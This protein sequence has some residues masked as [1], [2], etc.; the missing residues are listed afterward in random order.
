MEHTNNSYAKRTKIF[1]MII[2]LVISIFSFLSLVS[3]VDLIINSGTTTVGGNQNYETVYVAS[4]A[5]LQVDSSIGWLNITATNITILGTLN[6]LGMSNNTG[7]TA[8]GGGSPGGGGGTA[9]GSGGTGGGGGSVGGYLLPGIGGGGGGASAFQTGNQTLRNS[10]L[11]PGLGGGGGG[12]AGDGWPGAG[13]SGAVGGRG[14]AS[15]RLNS[16]YI[17]ITGTVTV[18]GAAGGSGGTAAC[19]SSGGFYAG[20]G[21]GGGGGANAGELIIDG[22]IVNVTGATL[23]AAGGSGGGGGGTEFPGGGGATGNGGRIKIFYTYLYNQSLSTSYSGTLGGTLYY[24]QFGTILNTTLNSPVNGYI[25]PT[26]NITFNCSSNI[27]FTTD[28]AFIQA[29]ELWTNYTGVWAVLQT[30]NYLASSFGDTYNSGTG[31]LNQTLW[32]NFTYTCGFGGGCLGGFCGGDYPSC[33]A[34]NQLAGTGDG[35]NTNFIQPVSSGGYICGM[36]AATRGRQD[37]KDGNYY[38]VTFNMTVY[39]TNNKRLLLKITNQSVTSTTLNCPSFTISEPAYQTLYSFQSTGYSST[40][41]KMYSLSINPNGTFQLF[42]STGLMSTTN[43]NLNHW[44][45]TWDAYEVCVYCGSGGIAAPAYLYIYNMSSQSLGRKNTTGIFNN[46]FPNLVPFVWNCNAFD[47]V[48]QSTFATA[49]RSISVD[50]VPP[51]VNVT[52]PI[53]TVSYAFVGQN[54][55]V[56]YTVEDTGA[57]SRCWLNYNN[58]N[59][60][61][62]CTANTT[63]IILSSQQSLTIYA[64]DTASNV[65]S[66]L[67]S[68]N[69]S[70][71]ENNFT[72]QPSAYETETQTFTINV[73][74]SNITSAYLNYNGTQYPTTNISNSVD[75]NIVSVTLDTP[76]VSSITIKS[77]NW[78]LNTLS[79]QFT[80]TNRTQTIHPINFTYCSPSVN[81]TYVNFVYY[82]EMPPNPSINASVPQ[83]TFNYWI[84]SGSVTK[85]YFFSN[86]TEVPNSRFCFSPPNKTITANYVY[87]AGGAAYVTRTFNSIVNVTYTNSSTTTNLYLIQTADSGPVTIQVIDLTSGNVIPNARVTITRQISGGQVI[88]IFDGYTDSAGTVGVWLSSVVSYTITAFKSGCGSN[89]Q[90]VTPVGSYNIQLNCAGNLTEYVSDI[91]GITYQRTPKD[92]VNSP[93]PTIFGYYVSS[94]LYPIVGSMFQI[95]DGDGNLIATNQTD[96]SSNYT[97]CNS[98]SCLLTINYTTA[99]GDNIKGRYYINLGNQTNYS[100]VLLEKDA[101]WRYIYIN[102][103]NSQ[104]AWKKTILHF[105]EFMNVWGNRN[106]N[107]IIYKDNSSCTANP[108]CKWLNQT[109]WDP[110]PPDYS[111]DVSFC[112]L[113][114][115]LNKMEFSRILIIFFGM[116]IV[117]FVLGRGVGYEM[118]NPGSFVMF[119][120]ISIVILSMGGLFTFSGLTP[121]DWFNQYI[122]AYICVVFSLGYNLSI[123]R[124]YSA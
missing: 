9:P 81:T 34:A 27:T 51:V 61:I 48:G 103:N 37:Y 72:Y 98:T 106:V 115:D 108:S 123:I 69:Y 24:E 33:I 99:S 102:T 47:S 80:T 64:N 90:T 39:N 65:G 114:D 84:G 120:T 17:L 13:G 87:Q 42:N 16:P 94:S 77:F 66:A 35:F 96:V 100:Y 58:V 2:F 49:N 46:T 50:S 83:A 32:E 78:V 70:M 44:Y 30:I 54:F 7:G 88:A 18:R 36:Y 14:G 121:W 38:N 15:V 6:G 63:S 62:N 75:F 105:D 91:D 45:L 23:N 59:T 119:L 118:T 25:S 109:D 20:G 101:Y 74:S 31:N 110:A 4:G 26:Q 1:G 92:G 10:P 12:G 21:G 41:A 113:K 57:L 67:G 56:N 5:T 71:I 111:K 40:A 117:L 29:L 76:T 28:N 82:D 8:G 43:I 79:G 73:S 86:T 116:V 55:T 53:G 124:R 93:G 19:C 85:T 22:A 68:W 52:Y 112:I 97:F 89:T 104:Q 95:Y 107:C 122:Y 60:T 3:A 11:N